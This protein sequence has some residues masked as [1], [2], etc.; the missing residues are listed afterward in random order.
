MNRC[1][2][3]FM[4]TP[5]NSSSHP[6]DRLGGRAELETAAAVVAEV[7]RKPGRTLH[8]LTGQ[9][10]AVHGKNDVHL[11]KAESRLRI[12]SA[13][14]RQKRG[15]RRQVEGVGLEGDESR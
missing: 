2:V 13:V 1:V 6:H 3:C 9:R 15:E 12:F 4:S 8:A 5:V 10:L 7:H 11:H 14:L